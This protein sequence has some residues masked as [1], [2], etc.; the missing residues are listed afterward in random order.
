MANV[1][2]DSFIENQIIGQTYIMNFGCERKKSAVMLLRTEKEKPHP[3]F[4]SF[5]T[6]NYNT[7]LKLMR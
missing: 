3:I 4:N 5:V 6:Y 7:K 1:S 2:T